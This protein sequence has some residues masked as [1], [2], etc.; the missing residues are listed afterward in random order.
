[1]KILF[2]SS[3]NKNKGISPIVHRQGQSLA[4]VGVEVYYYIIEGK[5]FIGYLRH[6]LPLCKEI[7]SK[8]YRLV[9][10][11]YS[12]S[13]MLAGIAC[14]F[15]RKPIICSL[16][17]SDLLVGKVALRFV[18]NF[19]SKYI[20]NEVIVK[21]DEMKQYLPNSLVV[22]NGVNMVH[23]TEKE[24]EKAFEVTKFSPLD[25]NIIF[26][27]NDLNSKVKNFELALSSVRL[28]NKEHIKLHALSNLSLD[29]LPYY[30]T[31]ADLLLITSLSEGSP[32]VVKEAMSCNCPIVATDVGNIRWLLGNLSNCYITSF[33][34]QDIVKKVELIL[35]Q[36]R[37]RTKGRV[38][39]ESLG[40]DSNSTASH[41]KSIYIGITH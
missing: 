38:R 36:N 25:R 17:G 16:M 3:G 37:A 2:V 32:N 4:I 27:A 26:V 29:D 35:S 24:I 8:E 22:P 30:Y 10:G 33:D 23:F 41:L 20:W 11:H 19:F 1:M 39:I 18:I 9:H 12:F 28:I 34:V 31:A 14:F 5:G 6:L 7:K 21:S 40:L 13:G 15:C